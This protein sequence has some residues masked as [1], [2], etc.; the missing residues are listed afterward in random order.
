MNIIEVKN[1]RFSYSKDEKD[2]VIKGID[3]NIEHGEFISIIGRNGSG[4]STLAGLLSALIM[5]DH[6]E[7]Y[8]NGI[9]TKDESK[10]FDL[11]QTIGVIFQ[12][13]DNQLVS[14][15][16]E[17]DV[18]FALENLGV[19]PKEM[20]N[21]IACA[22][23]SVD[24]LD[25]LKHSTHM[26]SGGQKQKIAIAGILA[27]N[28]SILVMDEPTAML[29]PIGR[30]N[31]IETIK[32]LNEKENKTIILV[33]HHM[34]EAIYAKRIFVLNEG[35][36]IIEGTPKEVFS[37]VEKIKKIGLDVPQPT[38]LIHELNKY[39]FNLKCDILTVEECVNE[40][41]KIFKENK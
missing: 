36:K 32:K 15:I 27:M 21:R 6:G 34:S 11:R 29:D 8:I 17:D 22:L 10:N 3:L 30:K 18:A 14:T 37:N 28:P 35:K 5:P 13:P 23:K 39:E 33:T 19:E 7:I 20:E 16:V 12:N 4:K 9:N 38:E 40:L 31:L 24:M 26:L 25:Y 2:E 1:L 41:T